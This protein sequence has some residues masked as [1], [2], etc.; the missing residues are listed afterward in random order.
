MNINLDYTFTPKYRGVNK[1]L[2]KIIN[3]PANNNNF[4][5]MLIGIKE[6]IELFKDIPIEKSNN[7]STPHWNNGWFPGLDG[8]S[9]YHLLVTNNPE[10]YIEIGSGNS[11]KFAR[12]AI[13]DHKL[14]TKI[15]SIDPKPR[16]EINAICDKIY[17][18]PCEEMDLSIFEKLP[19]KTIIFMDGSH[20]TFQN[21]DVTVFFTEILPILKKGMI[22][23]IHDIQ[24]PRD[25]MEKWKTRYYSEQYMLAAY[26]LGGNT[27]DEILLANFFITT[28]DKELL[29]ILNNEIFGD[30]YFDNF[31]TG[32]AALWLRKL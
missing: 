7:A 3:T 4:K 25:Y 12:R 27:Q 19:E 28:E 1:H 21:S 32:G 18:I 6:H 17:R 9:L 15:I 22:W 31:K 10:I 2:L 29:N 13:D 24:L 26:L 5:K 11:T 20:R 30:A 16:S 14:Q 8:A 23:G